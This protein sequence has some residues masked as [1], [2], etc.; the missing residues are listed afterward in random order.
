MFN[1][2][3]CRSEK[4]SIF[5]LGLFSNQMFNLAVGGSV[6][7]QLCVVYVPFF[8]SI[9][10][11]EAISLWDLLK[12]TLLTSSVFWSDEIRKYLARENIVL[13][14]SDRTGFKFQR[15]YSREIDG[16]INSV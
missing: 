13:K 15:Q 4:K 1:A 10:Q 5:T 16:P 9:F 12:I 11:T 7:G 3:A 2:L 14:K 6:V 8:Q